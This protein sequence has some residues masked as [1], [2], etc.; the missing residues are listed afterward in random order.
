MSWIV[1]V[2]A[3]SITHAV[4]FLVSGCRSDQGV[5]R[6]LY[7]DPI[8]IVVIEFGFVGRIS[9]FVSVGCIGLLIFESLNEKKRRDVQ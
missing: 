1:T 7:V 9:G 5:V 4:E 3:A 8:R 2:S 6:K